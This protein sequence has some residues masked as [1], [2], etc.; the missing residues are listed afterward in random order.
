MRP[1]S[2]PGPRPKEIPIS[3]NPTFPKCHP[4]A[5]HACRP[6]KEPKSS[7]ETAKPDSTPISISFQ[8]TPP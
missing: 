8:Q 6:Q 5:D 4:K 2:S 1:A 7:S 3:Q